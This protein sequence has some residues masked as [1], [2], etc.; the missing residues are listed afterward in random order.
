VPAKASSWPPYRLSPVRPRAKSDGD[1]AAEFIETFCRITKDSIAGRT[2]TPLVLRPWQRHLLHGLLERRPDGRLKHRQALIGMPRK[3][4]KSALASGIALWG[5]FCGPD[6][7]EVYSCAGDRDQ[8]RIVFGSAKRMVEM[9]SE[10]SGVAKLYRDVIEVPQTGAIYR[11][12]SS[13]AYSKE[14][15]NPTLTLFDEV[16]VQ[17][18]DELWN[19]MALASGSRPEPLMLGI[20]TAGARTDSLGGDTLCYRMYQH[21]CRVASGET[22]DP[23]FY[24]AWWEPAKGTEVDHTDPEAWREANP[25][26]D[27]LVDPEDFASSVKRTPEAEFRT[28]RTNVWVI[29]T[30]S[31][32][33]HGA[34]DACYSN[35]TVEPGTPEVLMCD[36]SWSGDSTGIVSATVEEVPHLRVVDVWERPPDDPAWRVPVAEVENTL[37]T[38]ARERN[39]LTV[40]FDPYR[41]QRSMQVLEEDGLPIVEFPTGSLPR[42]VPAWKAFYDA[43]MDGRVTHDGDPRLARH[44]ENMKLKLDH[45]GARPVKEHGASQRH[46]DLGICAVGA[47]SEAIDSGI[48][49]PEPFVV[50]A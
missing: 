34:W 39:C 42:M 33:P 13:E 47:Y 1:Q 28:K 41:W 8:A 29:S 45:R 19:V 49:A 20:T 2:G 32:F 31:A 12:L 18:N 4:G 46:I 16:H 15:L 26:Y 21:G 23:S 5:L 7:G 40:A 10:L 44:I 27:D 3:N 25:G 24:F 9:D 30:S 38:E 22:D 43:V 14:G 6:G 50:F 35:R 48:D 17:P 36:G 37:R 11:V